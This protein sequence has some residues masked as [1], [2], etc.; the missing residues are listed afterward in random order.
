MPNPNLNL[1]VVLDKKNQTA[2]VTDSTNYTALGINANDVYIALYIETPVGVLY[3]NSN[4]N[5]PTVNPDITGASHS[6]TANFLPLSADG[7]IIVGEYKL[8]Y[9]LAIYAGGDAAKTFYNY[10]NVVQYVESKSVCVKLDISCDCFCAKFTSKDITDYK[11]S[12]ELDYD[13]VIHYPQA[14]GEADEEAH[15]KV[16]SENRLANGTYNV[17]IT[18]N[19][20]WS[21]GIFSVIDEVKGNRDFKV[22]CTGLCDLKC[23]FTNLYEKYDKYSG[24]NPSDA[25]ILLDKLNKATLLISLMNF[26]RNC[27][28][29]DN[30]NK[31]LGKL[32]DILGDCN[33][34]CGGSGD[35]DDEDRGWISGIC[36]SISSPDF[37]TTDIYN[38]INNVNNNLTTLINSVSG[39]LSSLELVVN[40]LS[41]ASWLD[42]K[43]LAC[44]ISKG[45]PNT[46]KNAQE[47]FLLDSICDLLT[48]IEAQAPVAANDYFTTPFET[49]INC[50][51]T[52]ND[53]FASAVTVT[54]TT[55]PLNG[56][57]TILGDGKTIRYTPNAAFVGSDS[58]IY[59]ITDQQ[60]ATSSATLTIVVNPAAS[61][62]CSTVTPAYNASVYS[63]GA[64]LQIAIANQSGI[65]TN[66][67]SS[68]QY[69]IE[70]RDSS[71][72][73][74]YS[75]TVTGSPTSEPT[76]FTTPVPIASNWNNVRIQ[77]LLT[78]QSN[79]GAA[80]GT[81]TY[82][83]PT[84]FLLTNIT[85]SWF[86]GTTVPVCLGI[87]GVDTEV[88]KKNKLMQKICNAITSISV[89]NGISGVGTVTDPISLGGA[90]NKNT[91]INIG[92]FNFDLS[93]VNDN[94][95]NSNSYA[96][97]AESKVNTGGVE[98]NKT[99]K[100]S[101]WASLKIELDA[102]LTLQENKHGCVSAAIYRNDN[103]DLNGKIA[104][105][106]T[107][108]EYT[109]AGSSQW[110]I[111]FYAYP[112]TKYGGKPMFAGTITNYAGVFLEDTE[113]SNIKNNIVNKYGIYQA[114]ANDK[115]FLAGDVILDK[116]KNKSG[117][118]TDINGMI[119]PV[120]SDVR[121]KE[122]I[123][124]LEY[125]LSQILLLTP[126]KYNFKVQTNRGTH[127]EI[128]LIAQEVNTVIPELVEGEETE[129]SYL[130]V[131]YAN[132]T[133]V[134]V[135][136]IK[137]LNTKIGELETRIIAIESK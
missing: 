111:G 130:G 89:E 135:N 123:Q 116:N 129:N 59:K 4:F 57:A 80:C 68:K 42:G 104:S 27:G 14:V 48:A 120:V 5:D 86:D 8:G 72:G 101:V 37:D 21:Y 13:H 103:Y 100:S 115:N 118:A 84:P 95:L 40:A 9:T 6:Y 26:F 124:N 106:Y 61:S 62:A 119:V 87:T 131:K 3:M 114:G 39:D 16:Y 7:E 96:L 121:L 58:I 35:C 75:Y 91:Q 64:N 117:L 50:L 88:Q 51:V 93:K 36:G 32:K 45:M 98:S 22:D 20:K 44:L 18:T 74:L 122:N 81:V 97:Y 19:R 41:N 56:S 52:L 66:V 34:G 136:A 43:S 60:G 70:I 132:L 69:I 133:V 112:P 24:T 53:F 31:F 55:P 28:D 110:D 127:T 137:E 65:G 126:K 10:P 125:G 54:I 2:T 109:G 30:G 15:T 11:G 46:G 99:C 107:G 29:I 94:G 76:L 63:V 79:T 82:E 78:T 77:M 47:Q 23:A 128:G 25:K 90:L 17:E 108:S 1:S 33:C 49:A 113:L 134:L 73:I 12:A 38:T 83:T 105:F 71:N 102:N 85:I 92:D 67:I